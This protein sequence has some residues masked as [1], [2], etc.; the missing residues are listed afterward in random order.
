MFEKKRFSSRVYIVMWD[1]MFES[2]GLTDDVPEDL[3]LFFAANWV[4]VTFGFDEYMDDR[5]QRIIFYWMPFPSREREALHFCEV[6][7]DGCIL[8]SAPALRTSVM[9]PRKY[10]QMG[11]HT[12]AEFM[13]LGF[14]P[15]LL[16]ELGIDESDE[17]IEKLHR[18]RGFEEGYQQKLT[19]LR[20]VQLSEMLV[21]HFFVVPERLSY[22][23]PEV[24][25]KLVVWFNQDP[26]NENY[27]VIGV[28]SSNS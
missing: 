22:V 20:H 28:P 26:L 23:F 7:E 25:Q 3:K 11:I 14:K 15:L 24:Y 13:N 8:L 21:E 4:Q 27:P 12:A 17:F 16:K 2:K 6:H 10:Y 5:L 1:K 19:G 18:L 9:E